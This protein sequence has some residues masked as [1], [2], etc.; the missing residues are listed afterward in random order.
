CNGEQKKS[1]DV[2]EVPARR[3]IIRLA[4]TGQQFLSVNVHPPLRVGGLR[5]AFEGEVLGGYSLAAST[6]KLSGSRQTFM[7]Q[8]GSSRALSSGTLGLHSRTLSS[9]G[10]KEVSQ[11]SVYSQGKRF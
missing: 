11:H 8:M 6:L 1:Y 10:K 4:Y 9:K 3:P 5:C 7:A 2:V